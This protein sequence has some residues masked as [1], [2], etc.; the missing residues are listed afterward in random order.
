MCGFFFKF[1][2]VITRILSK[3]RILQIE[4]YVRWN[5]IQFVF[6]NVGLCV[7]CLKSFDVY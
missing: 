2:I 5:D 6:F 1:L 3:T 7:L 4:I